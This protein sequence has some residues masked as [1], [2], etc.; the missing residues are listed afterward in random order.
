M[1][2]L[3]PMVEAP[4]SSHSS[5]LSVPSFS[6]SIPAS[7]RRARVS[8]RSS[9]VQRLVARSCGLSKSEKLTNSSN[10]S[11]IATR[12]GMNNSVVAILYSRTPL[13]SQS[14]FSTVRGV[15]PSIS[16]GFTA[17]AF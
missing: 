16:A 8:L 12:M 17:S 15:T 13:P 5:A 11:G 6:L 14:C 1:F 9:R 2:P 7:V 3:S 10:C 4:N